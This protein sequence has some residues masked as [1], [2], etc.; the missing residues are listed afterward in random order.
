MHV[1]HCVHTSIDVRKMFYFVLL[2]FL[3][4]RTEKAAW[5]EQFGFN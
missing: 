2:F 5:L 1:T 4:V 3:N